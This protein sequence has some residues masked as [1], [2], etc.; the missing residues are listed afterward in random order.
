MGEDFPVAGLLGLLVMAAVALDL[1]LR[2]LPVL[3]S[4]AQRL[5][6]HTFWAAVVAIFLAMLLL[7]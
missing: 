2:P 4:R 3:A 1:I 5:R 6:R 7:A